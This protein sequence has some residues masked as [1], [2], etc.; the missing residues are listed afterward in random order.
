[1]LGG[2][3]ISVLS[4]SVIR[5]LRGKLLQLD[6]FGIFPKQ[7]RQ[8]GHRLLFAV[9]VCDEPGLVLIVAAAPVRIGHEVRPGL[10]ERLNGLLAGILIVLVGNFN[11]LA[12]H[13]QPPLS[14]PGNGLQLR[15]PSSLMWEPYLNR[16]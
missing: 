9:Q 12:C 10:Y 5:T 1:M 3:L 7:R 6:D 15:Y 4:D 11:Q 16:G 8:D 13:F 14:F 2:E